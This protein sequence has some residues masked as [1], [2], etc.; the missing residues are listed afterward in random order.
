MPINGTED[1]MKQLREKML[2]RRQLAKATKVIVIYMHVCNA[3]NIMH[4]QA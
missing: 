1:E 4:M 2:E 3:Y